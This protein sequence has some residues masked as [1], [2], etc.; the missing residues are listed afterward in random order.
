[1]PAL[2]GSP[3]A[4]GQDWSAGDRWKLR[5]RSAKPPG[6]HGMS[7]LMFDD[8]CWSWCIFFSG[9]H[10]SF[11]FQHFFEYLTWF[12]DIKTVVC[13]Y[14]KT[15][16]NTRKQGTASLRG[17][18]QWHWS[19][20]NLTIFLSNYVGI[21]GQQNDENIWFKII[22]RSATE[23]RLFGKTRRFRYAHI[24]FLP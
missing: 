21:Y 12:M 5:G 22:F 8:G 23:S 14:S 9:K 7:W 10:V 2:R 11:F 20:E 15:C 13:N 16:Q 19:H 1:M 4:P 18:K 6:D 24:G 3:G 17:K